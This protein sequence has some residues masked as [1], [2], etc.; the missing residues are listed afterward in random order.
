MFPDIET[1][2]KARAELARVGREIIAHAEDGERD[3]ETAIKQAA[4]TLGLLLAEM[5]ANETQVPVSA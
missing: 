4:Q 2:H 3:V 1:E 5:R